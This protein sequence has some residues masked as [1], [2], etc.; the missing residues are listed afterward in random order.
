MLASLGR[1]YA[2]T[3]RT[4]D[5]QRVLA[6]LQE[7]AKTHYVSPFFLALIYTGLHDDPHALDALDEAYQQHDWVLVWMSVSLA[8]DPLR[9]E[10]RFTDLL[11]R[12]NYPGGQAAFPTG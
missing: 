7:R 9:S 12:L 3:G 4:R 8:L 5:A 11:R 6:Q 2:V 1:T 10:P